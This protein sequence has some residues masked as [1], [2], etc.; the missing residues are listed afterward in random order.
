MAAISQQSVPSLLDI[1]LSE[2]FRETLDELEKGDPRRALGLYRAGGQFYL[3]YTKTNSLR[4][5][6]HAISFTE[7]ALQELPKPNKNTAEYATI[8]VTMLRDKAS[9]TESLHDADRYI[10]AI[11]MKIDLSM[12]G[13][14]HHEGIRE[15]GCAY[16]SRFGHSKD[17]K[18]INQAIEILQGCVSSTAAYSV[19]GYFVLVPLVVCLY[20]LHCLEFSSIS[21]SES[22]TYYTIT[23]Y[24]DPRCW[25][26]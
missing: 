20:P 3:D 23:C 19:D 24:L 10:E 16:Y 2:A 12:E 21:I 26:Q 15:L 11:R 5:L 9:M 22:R 13:T 1:F 25:I 8:L 18:D 4:S 17:V 6:D 7:E 14:L